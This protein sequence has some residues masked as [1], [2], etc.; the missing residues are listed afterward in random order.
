MRNTARL[1]V[2]LSLTGALVFS[3][4]CLAPQTVVAAE[5]LERFQATSCPTVTLQN[6][7]ASNRNEKLAFLFGLATMLELEKEWQY[8]TPLPIDRSL[9]SSWVRGLDGV[10]IGQMLQT[11]DNFVAANP[12]KLNMSVL[13]VLG[14]TYVKPRLTRQETEIAARRV[15]E[16]REKR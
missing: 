10:T 3:I 15:E 7:Q 12:D 6:W 2:L 1:S 4:F 11:V 9:N 16:I 14:R 8:K 13:E 5:K